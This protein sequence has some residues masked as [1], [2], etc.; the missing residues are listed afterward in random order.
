M[1]FIHY[2]LQANE[3]LAHNPKTF[4]NQIRKDPYLRTAYNTKT[5]K[6]LD[7]QKKIE[8]AYSAYQ[9]KLHITNKTAQ[10][11][12]DTLEIKE[13]YKIEDHLI[14]EDPRNYETD[15]WL[16]GEITLYILKGDQKI[17]IKSTDRSDIIYQNARNPIARIQTTCK[18]DHAI[19]IN[20]D[21]S[22]KAEISIIF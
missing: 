18:A 9:M 20:N 11:S 16:D 13:R 2:T 3:S 17:T 12:N 19:I 4:I 6:I 8:Q 22:K 21:G 1:E 10:A 15:E 5:G 7:T 14:L